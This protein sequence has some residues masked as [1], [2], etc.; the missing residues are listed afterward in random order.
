M[1][2]PDE[3]RNML[4]LA[5]VT[6]CLAM[7]GTLTLL[8]PPRQDRQADKQSTAIRQVRADDPGS[9]RVIGAP[10]VPNVNPR[11]R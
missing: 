6:L 4:L 10:F 5:A 7:A 8:D 3:N 2:I 9:V 1:R 11:E